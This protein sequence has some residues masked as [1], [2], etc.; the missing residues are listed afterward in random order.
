M[1]EKKP[2][3]EIA[4]EEVREAAQDFNRILDKLQ[5]SERGSER[6]FDLLCGDLFV[7][8]DIVRLKA[9]GAKQEADR[10]MN[11][12]DRLER[13]QNAQ[14]RKTNHR[15]ARHNRPRLSDLVRRRAS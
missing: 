3:A 5:Q 11:Q 15:A 7:K 6:Y 12:R 10:L 4:M 13:Q 8:A 9:A 2:L 14:K 1:S